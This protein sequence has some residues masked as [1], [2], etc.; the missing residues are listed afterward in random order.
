MKCSHYNLNF[1]ENEIQEHHIHPKFMDNKKGDGQKI[2]LCKKCHNILH[3]QIP[4][5]YWYLLNSNQKKEAIKIVTNI[6]KKYGN[7]K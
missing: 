1:K 7:I 6:S 4:L 3:L 2:N 5:Y